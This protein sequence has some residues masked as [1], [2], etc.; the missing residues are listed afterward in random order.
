MYSAKY[1]QCF[2]PYS[3]SVT[4]GQI[5]NSGTSLVNNRV[6]NSNAN[7]SYQSS[8]LCLSG[9][10]NCVESG[11]SVKYSLESISPMKNDPIFSS[12]TRP[13]PVSATVNSSICKINQ[14]DSSFHPIVKST[15]SNPSET[16]YLIHLQKIV[17]SKGISSNS[18]PFD[19]SS[20]SSSM[21]NIHSG[22]KVNLNRDSLFMNSF[23]LPIAASSASIHGPSHLIASDSTIHSSEAVKS[24]DSSSCYWLQSNSYPHAYDLLGNRLNNLT[25]ETTKLIHSKLHCNSNED[26]NS[27]RSKSITNKSKSQSKLS[28]IN[29]TTN[30]GRIGPIFDAVEVKKKPRCPRTCFTYEQLDML[31][32]YF[33]ESSQY[34]DANIKFTLAQLT[35]LSQARISVWFKNRRAKQRKAIKLSSNPLSTR[36]IPTHN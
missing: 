12:T 18:P 16:E 35:N 32:R 27:C 14:P 20:V 26:T 23:D 6:T 28:Q 33:N 13:P 31:E 19:I 17:N 9:I 25:P 11:N 2:H 29:E 5:S 7:S 3:I 15:I 4:E 8:G 24:F 30:G 10:S 21:R 34:P 22:Q 36:I 1:W